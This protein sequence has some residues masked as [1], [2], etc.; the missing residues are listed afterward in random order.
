MSTQI[1]VRDD[2]I[3]K[4]SKR[5]AEEKVDKL[6]KFFDGIQSIEV[7]LDTEGPQHRAEIVIAIVKGERLVSSIVHD[8]MNAAIDLVLDKAERV[9]VKHKEKVKEHRAVSVGELPPQRE[10]NPEEELESYD[11]IIDKTEF[12]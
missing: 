5:Y 12:N 6:N 1:T 7:I 3:S 2:S 11:D 4:S 10:P 8:Q 9:L